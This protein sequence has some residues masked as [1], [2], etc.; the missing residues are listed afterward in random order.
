MIGT[1]NH[2]KRSFE[3]EYMRRLLCGNPRLKITVWNPNVLE[4]ANK[5][6][7]P[8]ALLDPRHQS[9]KSVSQ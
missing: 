2:P 5:A 3:E 1:G 8:Q 4:G 6:L 9:I 7:L